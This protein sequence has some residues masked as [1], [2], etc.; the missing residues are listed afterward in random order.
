VIHFCITVFFQQVEFSPFCMI[1][2]PFLYRT[3][4]TLAL[5][6]LC[7]RKCL[8]PGKIIQWAGQCV[9]VDEC[10]LPSV[11]VP[12]SNQ[13][14]NYGE[15]FLRRYNSQLAIKGKSTPPYQ[16]ASLKFRNILSLIRNLRSPSPFSWAMCLH[17]LRLPQ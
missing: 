15:S 16:Q 14:H 1:I 7:A 6:I 11:C 10:S 3:L 12:T 9:C 5:Q 17:L 2:L 13:G 4:L 8:S